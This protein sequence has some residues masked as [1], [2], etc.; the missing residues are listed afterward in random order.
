[1][2]T[3]MKL[4]AKN[5]LGSDTTSVTFSSIPT[6]TDLYLVCT[7][8][9]DRA[10]FNADAVKIRFNGATADTNHSTRILYA[11]NTTVLSFTDTYLGIQ[12]TAATAAANTFASNEVYIPNYAGST[13]KSMSITAVTEDN[14]AA[15]AL[16]AAAGLWSNTAAITSMTLLPAF[17]TNLK[18]GSSFFLYGLTRA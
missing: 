1:M 7:I 13:N 5:V 15:T 6:F 11:S 2:P 3:T 10:S 12:A 16:V 9:T 17:G 18:S 4:I 8:R 14:V